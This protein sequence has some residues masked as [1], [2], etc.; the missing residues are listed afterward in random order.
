MSEL[1]FAC[2]VW[3]HKKVLSNKISR[4]R[5]IHAMNL[6]KDSMKSF[7]AWKKSINISQL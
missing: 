4:D 1:E 7:K 5:I 2:A 6:W 3:G